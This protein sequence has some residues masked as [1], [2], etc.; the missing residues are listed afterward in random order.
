MQIILLLIEK[1]GLKKKKIAFQQWMSIYIETPTS[2]TLTMAEISLVQI[3]IIM[4]CSFI[5][6]K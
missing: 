4:V 1:N 6:F 2:E 5:G 3:T